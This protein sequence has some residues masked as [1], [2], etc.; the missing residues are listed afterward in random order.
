MLAMMYTQIRVV[1]LTRKYADLTLHTIFS[2]DD[3]TCF[4]VS[5]YLYT[6]KAT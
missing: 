6:L 4:S 5:A 1:P 3:I 2:D